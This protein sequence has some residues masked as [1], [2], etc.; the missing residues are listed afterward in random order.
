MSQESLEQ[1]QQLILQ[2]VTLQK[3][4]RET[5]NLPAFL[6]LIVQ[7]GKEHNYDFTVEDVQHTLRIN[8]CAWLERW[9]P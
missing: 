2:N 8:Q 5:P 4:L 9:K 1:F 6:S 3:V 7:L